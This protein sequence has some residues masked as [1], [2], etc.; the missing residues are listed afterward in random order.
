M[1]LFRAPAAGYFLPPPALPG[2]PPLLSRWK[3]SIRP[4]GAWSGLGGGEAVGRPVPALPPGG[5]ESRGRA[6][7]GGVGGPGARGGSGGGRATAATARGAAV[8]TGGI[9]SW[10]GSGRATSASR[11]G[12]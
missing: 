8:G 11:G 6:A 5:G 2:P 12:R 7:P 3:L 10:L 4:A 1:F 9:T